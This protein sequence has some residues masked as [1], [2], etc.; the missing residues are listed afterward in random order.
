MPSRL[1]LISVPT[2]VGF[3][4]ESVAISVERTSAASITALPVAFTSA[5]LCSTSSAGACS[6]LPIRLLRTSAVFSARSISSLSSVSSSAMR[7]SISARRS[8]VTSPSS[9][10]ARFALSALISSSLIFLSPFHFAVLILS[11]H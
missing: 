2:R 11:V 10:F 9:S 3:A 1:S 5:A 8:A 7:V 4:R 6:S